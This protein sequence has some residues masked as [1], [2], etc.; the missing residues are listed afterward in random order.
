MNRS[1][2]SDRT[3]APTWLVLLHAAQRVETQ[4][5]AAL[6]DAGLSIAKLGVLRHLVDAG[7]PLQLG[8]LADRMACVKSNIT[9]LVDRLEAD[10]LVAR[11]GDPT[12]RRSVLAEITSEGR[13]RFAT[14]AKIVAEVEA[15]LFAGLDSDDRER[16]EAS[17][18]RIA[19]PC[20]ESK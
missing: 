8:K 10:G 12:D 17:L 11:N 20:A 5:E 16:L 1:S 14:G 18:A 9:Q 3:T 4:L 15:D 19:A 6:A 2:V 13:E 7:E